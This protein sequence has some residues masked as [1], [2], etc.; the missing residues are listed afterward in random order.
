LSP[1]EATAEK[2]EILKNLNRILAAVLCVSAGAFAASDSETNRPFISM[3]PL[4]NYVEGMTTMHHAKSERDDATGCSIQVTPFYQKMR[5][6]SETEIGK[7][8]GVNHLG[9]FKIG[10]KTEVAASPKTAQ[11]DARWFVHS[12]AIANQPAAANGGG[13][14]TVGDTSTSSSITINPERK[15]YGANACY[16]HNMNNIAKGLFFSVSSGITQAKHKLVAEFGTETEEHA[17]HKTAGKLSA[18]FA[19]T[20]TEQAG[21]Q[22][23]TVAA[24]VNDV[25]NGVAVIAAIAGAAMA[26]NGNISPAIAAGDAIQIN[27]HADSNQDVVAQ[28]IGVAGN[29]VGLTAAGAIVTVNAIGTNGI[30][31]AGINGTGDGLGGDI[32]AALRA[33]T[34]VSWGTVTG[35]S[36]NNVLVDTSNY[37]KQLKFG[38][39]D[40][41]KLYDRD[42]ATGINDVEMRLGWEFID[43]ENAHMCMDAVLL[44]PTG[45]K[46]TA[47]LLFEPLAGSRHV[48]VGTGLHA[49][50]LLHSSDNGCLKASLDANYRYGFEREIKRQIGIKNATTGASLPWGH[51]RLAAKKDLDLNK[52]LEPAA[53][54]LPKDVKVTPGH[55]FDGSIMLSACAKN[56]VLDVGYNLFA[57]QK[58]GVKLSNAWTDDTYYIV[59][60]KYDTGKSFVD[61]N[62]SAGEAMA[63]NNSNLDMDVESQVIH[64][65]F[66]GIGV[67]MNDMEYP[68]TIGVGGSIEKVQGDR[69][70]IT[71]QNYEVWGKVGISF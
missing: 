57:C 2:G 39:I 1:D 68:V 64:R 55:M 62:G 50:G 20:A 67:A 60:P 19:G 15:A 17:I 21:A 27:A 59:D 46:P 13:A 41:D 7:G 54:I 16:R 45:K 9:E 51:Y 58:Q 3:R 63:I 31:A 47:E 22:I 48:Q 12:R 28:R 38:V 69:K 29:I 32:N 14:L 18:Y 49:N 24:A 25:G 36:G 70:Q 44:I 66:A 43:R 65:A 71:P 33:G 26:T 37:Q 5:G 10:N 35:Y 56:F 30:T 61:N 23:S 52:G 6:E 4:R 8:F 53:N 42:T 34:T 40:D 11:I